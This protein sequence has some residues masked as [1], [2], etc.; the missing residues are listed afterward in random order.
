MLC[1]RLHLCSCSTLLHRSSWPKFF[2]SQHLVVQWNPVKQILKIPRKSY[3]LSGKFLK[4]VILMKRENFGAFLSW[5]VRRE[6]FLTGFF[7]S[8]FHCVCLMFRGMFMFIFIANCVFSVQQF[9]YMQTHDSNCNT[10]L[11][12]ETHVCFHTPCCLF[13]CIFPVLFVWSMA[14]LFVVM[15]HSWDVNCMSTVLAVTQQNQTNSVQQSP[16]W[17][18]N[19]SSASQEIPRILCEPSISL[20]WSQQPDTCPYCESD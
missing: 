17:Q 2:V 3:F 18:V 10:Y 5:L 14:L 7:L 1:Y 4:R 16:S 8:E 19:C 9:L 11:C 6:I 12:T 13:A 15:Q 20:P